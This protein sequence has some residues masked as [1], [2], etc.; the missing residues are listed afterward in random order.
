MARESLVAHTRHDH[1]WLHHECL[2]GR[3]FRATAGALKHHHGCP[4]SQRWMDEQVAAGNLQPVAGGSRGA[5]R[6]ASPEP[7]ERVTR[8]SKRRAET[9]AGASTRSKAK[10]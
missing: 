5:S 8:G 3:K 6:E 4:D 2:C 10:K 9:D 7:A 1:L